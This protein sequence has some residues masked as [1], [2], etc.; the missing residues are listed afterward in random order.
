MSR[1]KFRFLIGCIAVFASGFHAGFLRADS[2][3]LISIADTTLIEAVPDNNLGGGLAVNTGTTQN[4]TRN[5]GL[6]FFDVT[7]IPLG[8]RVTNVDFVVEV[9]GQFKDGFASSSFGLHRVLKSW[10]EGNKLSPDPGH[11]GLGAAA[12]IGEATWKDRF[13]FTTN[14]WTMPGGMATND[15][16]SES[17]AVTFVFGVGDSPYTFASTPA[18]AADVQAWVDD[19]S[20]NFGWML[21]CESEA[22][23]FTARRF[24]S[25][26]DTDLEP[27]VL[28]QYDPPPHVDLVAATNAQVNLSFTAQSNQSYTVEFRVSFS[29]S[30][31]WLTLTNFPV[32]PVT[33]ERMISDSLTQAQ[34]YY[35]LRLP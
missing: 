35:R 6:F 1:R 10:G 13:A 21:I 33:I 32:A 2:A 17:S 4:F 31:T 3:L 16:V 15:Y 8:S 28:V 29:S 12:T 14:T 34:R 24:A 11:P 26:E 25:R 5:R 30:D 7:G 19:P 9:T 27:Y 22:D 23:N 18:L 20:T